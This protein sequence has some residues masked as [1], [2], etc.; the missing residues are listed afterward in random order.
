MSAGPNQK[1]ERLPIPQTEPKPDVK[2]VE[3][4]KSAPS[5]TPNR[6]KRAIE[7]NSVEYDSVPRKP[8]Y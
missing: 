3:N 8:R 1:R 2:R 6:A 5:M 4:K 7:Y